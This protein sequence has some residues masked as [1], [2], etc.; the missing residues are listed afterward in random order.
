MIAKGLVGDSIAQIWKNPSVET[1]SYLA[2]GILIWALMI[3]GS[4]KFARYYQMR[5]EAQQGNMPTNDTNN[6]SSTVKNSEAD[7]CAA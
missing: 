5:K 6:A 4:Q 3:W 1:I 7:E 2:I